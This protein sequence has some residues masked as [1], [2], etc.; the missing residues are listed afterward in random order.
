MT[1]SEDIRNGNTVLFLQFDILES[2]EHKNF[3]YG[4]GKHYD[5]AFK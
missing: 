5:N 4:V 3:A 2:F 1:V